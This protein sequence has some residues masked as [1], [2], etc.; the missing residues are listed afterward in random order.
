MV[1][2]TYR[3]LYA[4]VVADDG[5][6][7]I[8]Y[9]TWLKVLGFFQHAAGYEI[10]GPGGE[11]IVVHA[12]GPASVHAQGTDGVA[13]RFPTSLG[14][15]ILSCR[16]TAPTTPIDHRPIGGL[17]WRV[18]VGSGDAEARGIA[19]PQ[20]R[21][22]GRGYSDWISF[23]RSP[24]RMGIGRVQWG[25]AHV[26]TRSIVFNRVTMASGAT[27]QT[28]WDGQE[29]S[30]DLQ[31]I[32]KEG[33]LA[34]VHA[35]THVVAVDAVRVLHQGDALDRERMPHRSQRAVARAL[36][37]PIREVRLLSKAALEGAAGVALH[38]DVR[39]GRP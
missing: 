37:G 22:C 3:K 7:C 34:E 16:A 26:G 1:M 39:L 8:V 11:R 5:T 31:L 2:L 19:G 4:D 17:S 15:F 21:M 14:P 6:V 10:Y 24:R 30:T 35:G 32:E 36:A 33:R 27:W 38:E 25:R 12:I 13:L 29:W 28:T 9:A 23:G 18:L 20:R